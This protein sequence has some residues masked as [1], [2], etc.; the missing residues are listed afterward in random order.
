MSVITYANPVILEAETTRA[1]FLRRVGALTFFGLVLACISGVI[2][3][4]VVFLIPAL[5]SQVMSMVVI[6]GAWGIVHFVARPMAYSGS[7]ATRGTGFLLGSVF[8]GIAMGYLLLG[9]ALSS[10]DLFGN[11]FIIIGQALGLT[12]ATAA[13]MLLYLMTGPKQLSLVKAIMPMLGLPMIV[14]MVISFIFPISG[15]MGMALSGLFVVFSACGLLYQLNKVVHNMP[16][17]MPIQA[18][19]EVMIGLL[20]LFWNILV[21]L[22]RLQRR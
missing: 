15:P 10:L 11:P 2:S 3:A 18:S 1:A 22:M 12:G 13:G 7:V 9:A 14:L 19:F 16:A 17:D 20:V 21:L 4:G 5:A 8:Q 6:F